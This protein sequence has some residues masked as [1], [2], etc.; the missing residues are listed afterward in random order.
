MAHEDDNGIHIEDDDARGAHTTGIMR[1]VL[2]ISLLLAIIA[3]S[4][5]WI[6]PALTGSAN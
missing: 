4:V 3:M 5:I 2:G 1:Y 6:V